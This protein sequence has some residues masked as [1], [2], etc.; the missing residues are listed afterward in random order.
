MQRVRYSAVLLFGSLLVSTGAAGQDVTGY[1]SVD[2]STVRTPDFM[3]IYGPASPP[4]GFVRF[5]EKRPE[6][7]SGDNGPE[8]RVD[9]NSDRLT[10]LDDINRLINHAIA[11]ATDLEVY[12]IKEYWTLPST[13]G[14]CEDYALLKRRMLIARGWPVSSLLLTVVRDEKGDGHAV[15]TARTLQ[16]DFI[17]DNK[18][19][20][21]LLWNRTPYEFVM[22]QSYLDPRV[23]VALDARHTPV[24]TALSGVQNDS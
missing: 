24:S 11:P 20:K 8:S 17:L 9:A 21:L 19:E 2:Q 5:C 18:V 12:G 14:D 1:R 6:E 13:R 3:R 22:R 4:H 10:E 16:G 7:C 15:L 23:W